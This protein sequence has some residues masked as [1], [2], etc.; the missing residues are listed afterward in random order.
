MIKCDFHV[1][2]NFCDGKNSPEQVVEQAIKLN[3]EKLGLC[4]HS[5]TFFDESYCVRKER[6][7][8]F[9]ETVH[10]LKDKYRDKLEIYC[11][12]EQD[13]Y[14]E[15]PTDIYDY[16][17]GSIHYHKKNGEYFPLDYKKEIFVRAI[18]KHYGG[19]YIKFAQEYFE[20]ASD[21]VNKTGADIIGHFDV[22]RKFNGDG[23]LFD[24]NNPDYRI[25]VNK[26]IEK[27]VSYGKPFEINTGAISR[28][29]LDNPYPA[30]YAIDYAK[31]LGGKFILS[32][33]A[34]TLENLLFGF[35]R[36]ENLIK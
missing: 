18:E 12:V 29:Y 19:D 27:L 26:A 3:M 4:V 15:E 6:Q 32:S 5:Y 25:A 9:V 21:V 22:I 24:E 7:K 34:H 35:G 20:V 1:H 13:Y 10:A 31:L 33:D 23:K 16:V 30:S 14:S 17:I 2:T 11:G 8:E 28:G 36:F